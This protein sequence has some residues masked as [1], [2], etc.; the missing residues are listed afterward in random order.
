[1]RQPVVAVIRA[2]AGDSMVD[3]NDGQTG[4]PVA[5]PGCMEDE[6]AVR[7]GWIEVG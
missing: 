7:E 1:M 5:R 6:G 4:V 2:V 3:E